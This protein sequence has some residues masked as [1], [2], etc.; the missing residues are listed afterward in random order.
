[1]KNKDGSTKYALYLRQLRALNEK[2][3][4]WIK[5]RDALLQ[6]TKG[7]MIAVFRE[8]TKT[9]LAKGSSVQH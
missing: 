1:M 3:P 8:Y 5:R 7:R 4:E 6:L 9:A 2:N